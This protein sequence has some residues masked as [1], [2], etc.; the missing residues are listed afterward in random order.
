MARSAVAIATLTLFILSTTLA[1]N[2]NTD[3]SATDTSGDY[4]DYSSPSPPTGDY[5][6]NDSGGGDYNSPS[7]GSGD[8]YSPSPGDYSPSPGGDYSP[9]PGGDYSPP[10]PDYAPAAGDSPAPDYQSPSSDEYSPSPDVPSSSAGGVTAAPLLDNCPSAVGT[11]CLSYTASGQPQLSEVMTMVASDLATKAYNTSAEGIAYAKNTL[12]AQD[13]RFISNSATGTQVLITIDNS[14][15]IV[16]F[17]GTEMTESADIT[18]NTLVELVPTSFGSAGTGSVHKG[19][20]QAV[21]SVYSDLTAILRESNPGSTKRLYFTGH[22]LGSALATLGSA[23]V[24]A[25]SALGQ[26]VS[27]VYSLAGPRVGDASWAEAYAKLGL[28]S[29][30]LRIVFYKD[31]VPLVPPESMKYKHVGRSAIL[32]VDASTCAEQ[33]QDEYDVCEVDGSIYN[34]L[35]V[36]G[37]QYTCASL[38]NIGIGAFCTLNEE[39]A[40]A[41]AMCPF[42]DAESLLGNLCCAAIEIIDHA[43]AFLVSRYIVH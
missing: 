29:K 36:L 43:E 37:S 3:Y 2:S 33:S 13:A 8:Y 5:S 1:Q 15:I 17:R 18:T 35:S 30:T 39:S 21:E 25:D 6:A 26:T 4:G 28:D 41:K 32:P 20:L 12:G 38:G 27:G 19:F 16:S 22:S 42:L 9:S 7:A 11:S 31:A 23:K 10:S 24:Q 14:A 34:F 40:Y